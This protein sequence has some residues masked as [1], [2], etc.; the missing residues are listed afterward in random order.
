MNCIFCLKCLILISTFFC[1]LQNADLQVPTNKWRER[2]EGSLEGGVCINSYR[3]TEGDQHTSSKGTESWGFAFTLFQGKGKRTKVWSK[4]S[5]EQRMFGHE[6]GCS[7]GRVET[8]SQTSY[9]PMED[10][11]SLILFW[12]NNFVCLSLLIRVPSEKLFSWVKKRRIST[13]Q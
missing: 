12:W 7:W 2:L 8:Q 4:T 6:G 3:S 9:Y 1:Q 10:K 13:L 11:S 5:K